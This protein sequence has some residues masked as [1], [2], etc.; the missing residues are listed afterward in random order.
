MLW[1]LCFA[2]HLMSTLCHAVVTQRCGMIGNKTASRL[3]ELLLL[4]KIAGG[5][6]SQEFAWPWAGQLVDRTGGRCGCVLI[7]SRF[8]LTAAHCLHRR[9]QT[10]D[11]KIYFG[12]TQENSGS[13]YTIAKVVFHPLYG[14]GL[15]NDIAILKLDRR[16][17]ISAKISPVCLPTMPVQDYKVCTVVGWGRTGEGKR[18]TR[19]LNEVHV[20]VMPFLECYKYYSVAIDPSSMFCAG[21]NVGGVDACKVSFII[22]CCRLL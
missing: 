5:A 7:H 19:K 14:I 6:P 2:V 21:F 11:Y 20:P 15:A 10:T 12:S 18:T 22:K 16:A 17:T 3:N 1:R 9:G 4:N 13:V 8:A